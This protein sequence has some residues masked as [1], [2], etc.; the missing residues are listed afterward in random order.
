MSL[1]FFRVRPEEGGAFFSSDRSIA[2]TAV[3]TSSRILKLLCVTM[4]IM[5]FITSIALLVNV[6]QAWPFVLRAGL[7]GF[8]FF[9]AVAVFMQITVSRPPVRIDISGQGHIRLVSRRDKAVA[10]S[11]KIR[12][13]DD[14]VLLLQPN[15]FIFSSLLL[16]RLKDET[17]Q[18]KSLLIFPDCVSSSAFRRLSVACRW[19]AGQNQ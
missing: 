2:V 5:L 19:I 9:S 17:G 11:A 7:S 14:C 10:S 12:S 18:T 16:L 1:P 8:A 6:E 3:I 4:A 13:D 15:S